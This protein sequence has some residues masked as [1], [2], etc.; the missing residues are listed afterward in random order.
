MEEEKIIEPKTT[1]D[2]SKLLQQKRKER[3]EGQ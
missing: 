2:L 3:D 1:A